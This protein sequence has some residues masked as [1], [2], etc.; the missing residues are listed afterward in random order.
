M[1]FRKASKRTDKRK[2]SFKNRRKTQPPESKLSP[3]HLPEDEGWGQAENKH[4]H[5]PPL[6]KLRGGGWGEK[7][8]N[9]VF[10]ANGWGG[11]ESTGS[12]NLLVSVVGRLLIDLYKFLQSDS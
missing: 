8:L 9:N 4:N 6:Q 2:Q 5:L 12:H 1:G 3:L 7:S 11:L 10:A